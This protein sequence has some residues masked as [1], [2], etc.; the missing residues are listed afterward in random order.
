VARHSAEV[1]RRRRIAVGAGALVVLGISGGLTYTGVALFAPLPPAAV[2]IAEPIVEPAPPASVATPDFGAAG[3]AA[4]GWA[5]PL[6][7]TGDDTPRPMASITKVITALVA[8]EALPLG[9]GEEGPSI[10]LTEL[11]ER[12]YAEAEA[13][14]ESR[15]PASAGQVLTERDVLEAMLLR[16]GGNYARTL[17]DWAYGDQEAFLAAAREWLAVN[18]MSSTTITEPTG[19]HPGNASTIADLLK[20]GALALSQPAIAEIVRQ[21]TAEVPGVGLIDTTNTLLGIDGVDGIKTGTTPE[22]GACLL[23]STDIV[24]GA[25][26]I[27]LI[28][29]VLG[30]PDR[31]SVDAAVLSLIDTAR[32][33]FHELDVLAAGMGLAEYETEWGER[34]TARAAGPATVLVWG[35]ERPIVD[36]A[37]GEVATA[38]AGELVGV[39]TVT[40]PRDHLEID[41]VLDAPLADPGVGWRLANPG[42]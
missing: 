16:S 1:Y 39:A 5:S 41:I 13:N 14:A 36:I 10:T 40:T 17:A 2:T 29:A 6:T 18:G 25:E 26:T 22:A 9:A 11:D 24:V 31:A 20:L 32:T 27:T 35:D 37:V 3:I 12:Y 7:I 30:G 34:A 23:F 8:L 21:S 33:G 42:R 19:A 15:V 4:S 38:E 28:G